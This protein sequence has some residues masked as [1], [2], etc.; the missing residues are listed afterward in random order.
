MP[1][2]RAANGTCLW[3]GP[4]PQDN[5]LSL[6][7]S[8]GIACSG[9]GLVAAT[10]RR[11]GS[12]PLAASGER[13]TVQILDVRVSGVCND[14]VCDACSGCRSVGIGLVSSRFL[15]LIH[16]SEPTRRTPR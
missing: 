10:C 9:M 6:E 1:A 3:P 14:R 7:R 5:A 12:E 2:Q 16:I 4:G 13:T 15:S 11:C 8:G